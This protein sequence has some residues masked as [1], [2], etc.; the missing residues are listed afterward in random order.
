[1]K[2]FEGD[3]LI[4]MKKIADNSIDCVI[5]DLPYGE[6]NKKGIWKPRFKHLDW[7]TPVDLK[8]MWKELNRICKDTTPIFLFGDMKFGVELINSNPKNF[9]YE[10]IWS[11]G[12]S[13]TPLLSKKRLGKSTE[14]VFIFYKKQCVY[15]Y[16][17]YHKILKR[18]KEYFNGSFVG[19]KKIKKQTNYYIPALPLNVIKTE[20][21]PYRKYQGTGNEPIWNPRLPLNVITCSKGV[22][23]HKLIKNITEKPQ[24]ILEFLL[25]YFSNEGDNVLD[26][27][28]GSGSTG[29]ACNTLKRN[30][31]GIE[32]KKEHFEIAK[33][34]LL[35]EK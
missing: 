32:K 26:F 19:A 23:K 15:N 11:K 17:K 18:E 1:M 2:L 27:C 3:C 10:L 12:K 24:G 34:R 21:M 5:A 14:Y 6:K 7:C 35:I 22:R 8:L 4:E 16:A 29:V 28:M 9:K 20:L 33:K 30:F 25:K 13:T 31:I